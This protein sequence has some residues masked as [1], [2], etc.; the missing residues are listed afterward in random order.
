MC[1]KVNL[2]LNVFET[3]NEAVIDY[4]LDLN[5]DVEG[6]IVINKYTWVN[7][8]KDKKSCAIKS[9]GGFVK[10]LEYNDKEGYKAFIIPKIKTLNFQKTSSQIETQFTSL[11]DDIH[12]EGNDKTI[13]F[14]K[15]KDLLSSYILCPIEQEDATEEP[16]DLSDTESDDEIESD[17]TN[18]NNNSNSN[19]NANDNANA[20]SNSNDNSNSNANANDNANANSNA[21]SNDNAEIR[22]TEELQKQFDEEKR[23]TQDTIAVNNEKIKTLNRLVES[24]KSEKNELQT[25]VNEQ[26]D[27]YRKIETTNKNE[28]EE[29]KTENERLKGEK[30]ALEGELAT[31]QKVTQISKK[32]EELTPPP[33]Q[34]SSIKSNN[35]S[36]EFVEDP[37]NLEPVIQSPSNEEMPNIVPPDMTAREPSKMSRNNIMPSEMMPSEMMQSEMSRNNMMPSEMS[38]NNMMQSEKSRNN[39]MPYEPSV[40]EMSDIS[41]NLSTPNSNNN[42]YPPSEQ[43]PVQ[44]PEQPPVQS[45]EQAPAQ[46]PEQSLSPPSEQDSEQPP[47]QSPEQALAPAPEQAPGSEQSLSPPSEQDSEQAPAP[48]PEQGGLLS[49]IKSG[50]LNIFSSLTGNSK[51]TEQVGSGV[52]NSFNNALNKLLLSTDGEKSQSGGGGID[53]DDDCFCKIAP[54]LE[55]LI[56]LLEKSNKFKDKKLIADIKSKVRKMKSQ[57]QGGGGLLSGITDGLDEQA[58]VIKGFFKRG[59]NKDIQELIRELKA[60]NQL[61]ENNRQFNSVVDDYNEIERQYGGDTLDSQIHEKFN[62]GPKSSKNNTL[63]GGKRSKL[64]KRTRVR[65]IKRRTRKRGELVKRSMK[66]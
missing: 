42:N 49:G 33:L 2:E 20:N 10:K 14:Y 48:A 15:N 51:D 28:L 47:V 1:D 23:I 63:I 30:A 22:R 50:L 53:G 34:Q 36:S 58:N 27:E 29:L 59:G 7:G 57:S 56:V 6:K 8:A 16:D 66:K 40:T 64:K 12:I 62:V 31:V 65:C 32:E 41:S 21:N 60:Q 19:A 11:T 26:E 38:R 25:K 55:T 3:K 9:Y 37:S 18:S 17:N 24:L 44:S 43:A 39:M 45:P 52:I 46:S 54:I 4:L 13:T 61:L 35:I 5:S